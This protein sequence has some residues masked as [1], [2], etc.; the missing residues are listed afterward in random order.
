MKYKEITKELGQNIEL[1]FYLEL[2]SDVVYNL[3]LILRSI[4]N[5]KLSFKLFTELDIELKRETE[6]S[7]DISEI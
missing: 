6:K 5:P 1:G 4:L 2:N 7:W 3:S